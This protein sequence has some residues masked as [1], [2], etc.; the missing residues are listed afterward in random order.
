M[1][2]ADDGRRSRDIDGRFFILRPEALRACV[3][4]R[5]ALR[6]DD[7]GQRQDARE[8]YQCAANQVRT[9]KASERTGPAAQSEVVSGFRLR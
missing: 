1:S 2:P 4:S 9:H 7:G 6:E 8:C 3:V 5:P